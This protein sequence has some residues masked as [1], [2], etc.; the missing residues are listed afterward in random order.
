MT[1]SMMHI[2]HHMPRFILQTLFESQRFSTI[3]LDM[4]AWSEISTLDG[5]GHA[6]S[7]LRRITSC[8]G[9]HDCL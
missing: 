9:C 7:L 2:S 8:I 5:F 6:S 1:R 4:T 3:A